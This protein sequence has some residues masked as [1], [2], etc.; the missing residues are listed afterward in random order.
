VQ[1]DSHFTIGH[2]HL[3]GGKPCQ[4][5]A[6]AG[7]LPNGAAYAIAADG[8][9]TG[10]MNDVGARVLTLSTAQAIREHWSTTRSTADPEAAARIAIKQQVVMAAAEGVLGC[11]TSDML[12][13]CLYAYLSPKG[14]FAHVQGDGV[15]AWQYS[16]GHIMMVRFDWMDNKPLYPAYAGDHFVAFIAAHGGDVNAARL[17]RDTWELAPGKD[18]FQ[19]ALEEYSL[20]QG[21][22][23]IGL[24]FDP[25]DQPR[26]I[27]VFTDG[28]TQIEGLDWKDAVAQLLSFKTTAGEFAKRRLIRMVKDA[29][30]DGRGPLDD[31][32]Y[33][34]IHTDG[35]VAT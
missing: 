15:V 34:V 33:A 8:C 14:G 24:P 31:L 16:D 2:A 10:G 18:F 35:E 20:G 27:A 5:Y 4:D 26:F 32:A 19:F 12:A 17:T 28:V 6:A 7:N 3:T 9:S 13:T 23:G 25:A 21:I 22:S 11:G 30:Q 1:T 29:Q